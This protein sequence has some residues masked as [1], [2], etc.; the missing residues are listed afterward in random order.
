[1]SNSLT[2]STLSHTHNSYSPIYLIVKLKKKAHCIH[3]ELIPSN[4]RE[5]R[6]CHNS[7]SKCKSDHENKKSQ[8][9]FCKYP[10]HI[11]FSRA[12]IAIKQ[13]RDV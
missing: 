3:E 7:D 13:R 11:F 8:E 10:R 4:N 5:A 1:M 12:I 6:E 2:R 9:H